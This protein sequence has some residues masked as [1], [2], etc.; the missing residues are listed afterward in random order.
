MKLN[1][2]I[3]KDVVK[4]YYQTKILANEVEDPKAIIPNQ[5]VF[6]LFNIYVINVMKK[7]IPT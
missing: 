1:K 4:V 6:K 3:V 5:E 2:P 7:V